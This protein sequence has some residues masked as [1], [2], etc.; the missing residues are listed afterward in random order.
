MYSYIICISWNEM[1]S[2]ASHVIHE[3]SSL[4]YVVCSW[5]LKEK[6]ML[7]KKE[8]SCCFGSMFSR[9]YYCTRQWRSWDVFLTKVR[10]FIFSQLVIIDKHCLFI[11]SIDKCS[12][13]RRNEEIEIQ[14]LTT[15]Q[16]ILAKLM[17]RSQYFWQ[18]ISC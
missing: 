5:D 2:I 13:S 10:I 18:P 14:F 8:T 3:I 1:L 15:G 11:V 7:Y 6:T 16:K 9:I 4:Y 12:P 17:A